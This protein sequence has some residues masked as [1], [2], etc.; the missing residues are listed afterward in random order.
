ML[1]VKTTLAP[2]SIEGL[3]VFAAEGIKAG[4]IVWKFVPGV[5]LLLSDEKISRLPNIVTEVCER[6]AYRHGRMNNYVLC[7]DDARFVNH[8]DDPNTMGIYP[9]GDDQGFDIATRDIE[10]GEEITCDY[11]TF[12]PEFVKKLGMQRPNFLNNAA[13]DN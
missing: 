3:G 6:Y 11:R 13:R 9:P 2:S 1:L 5:D 7:G 8:S 10:E 4:T 12:D